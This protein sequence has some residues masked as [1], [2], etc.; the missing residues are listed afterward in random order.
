L[1]RERIAGRQAK[2]VTAVADHHVSF[3]WQ[4]TRDF[5][6]EFRSRDRPSNHKGSSGANVHDIE[7]LQLLRQDARA[8]GPVPANVD[9]FE[10]NNQHRLSS[11]GGFERPT[12]SASHG[13]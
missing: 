11:T 12:G 8:K 9:A 1:T 10:E 4:S 7:V 5:C 13:G 6:A 2:H 3:E